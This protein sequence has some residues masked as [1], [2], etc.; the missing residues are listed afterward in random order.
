MVRSI[1]N[2]IIE[3]ENQ[4]EGRQEAVLKRLKK[5]QQIKFFEDDIKVYY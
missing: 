3:D 4:L 2:Q 5:K 1:R